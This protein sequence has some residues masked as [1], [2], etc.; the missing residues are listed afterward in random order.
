MLVA[1]SQKIRAQLG[2]TS[3]E[4]EFAAMISD[5]WDWMQANPHGYST[6]VAG[7]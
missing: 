7:C 1:L 3:V 2:W 4:P 5:A 6:G